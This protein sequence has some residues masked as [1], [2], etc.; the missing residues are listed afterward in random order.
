MRFVDTFLF[1]EPHEADVLWVK[2]NV[3][4]HLVHEWVVV[5]NAYTHQGGYKGHYLNELVLADERFDRFLP[6]L[7]VI[8]S[9]IK[10]DFPVGGRTVLD[11]EAVRIER[12][13]REAALPH[14]L[15]KY[16]DQ[17]YVL[18]S[19][20]DECMDTE[21]AKR[22]RLLRSKVATGEDIILVPRIRYCFDYDNRKLARRCVPLV[23]IKQLKRDG[24]LNHY[25]EQLLVTPV[26]WKH[27]MVFEYSYC[28]PR[29]SI[30]RKYETM[31][32]VGFERADLDI[33]LRHNHRH[34]SE[35]RMSRYGSRPLD[36]T[37]E[38]WFVKRRLNSR[39]SP[40]FVRE[41]FAELRTDV[42]SPDYK[43]NRM[44]TYPQYFPKSRVRRAR[45]WVVL[46]RNMYI[47][48]VVH[49][50][51]AY[52]RVLAGRKIASALRRPGRLARIKR[53][54][55]RRKKDTARE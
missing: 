1:S 19:D 48:L 34:I 51:R 41:H 54:L 25:R 28:Y 30:L 39:N 40:A 33:A 31:S 46:Y 9:D 16:A 44:E 52:R 38:T 21:A 8:E 10:P 26:I 42:V 37:A 23:S 17:D 36:W 55:R 35:Y 20:V 29:D 15:E 3:E 14:L 49:N 27:E 53:Y 24:R 13:Q 50:S 32:H 11:S 47:D 5:E 45:N 22:R 6:K 43:R 7:Q 2:L 4:D 12:A 18:I